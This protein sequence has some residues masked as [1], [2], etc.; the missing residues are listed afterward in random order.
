[1]QLI[2]IATCLVDLANKGNKVFEYI[3]SNGD[4]R[5]EILNDVLHVEI[6]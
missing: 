1:M 3:D 2:E 6:L 5:L 4:S